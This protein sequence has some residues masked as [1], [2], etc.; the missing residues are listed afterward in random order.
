MTW[1][2]ER[3]NRDGS[4]AARTYCQTSQTSDETTTTLTLGRALDSDMVID[5]PYVAASHVRLDI[6]PDGNVSVI[7]LGTKNKI[8][9]SRKKHVDSIVITTDASQSQHA[10]FYVGQTQM[11]LTRTDWP[12]A[13]ER[14]LSRRN[15]WPYAIT[16]FIAALLYSA[17]NIWLG[18]VGEKP[19]QYLNLIAATAAGLAIWSA[20]YAIF[21]RLISGVDRMFSHLA[22]ACIGFLSGSFVL[23]ILETF[24]FATSW[25]WPI[26]ITDTVVVIAAAMTVAFHLK[27]ADPRHWRS[28]RIAIAVIACLAIIVPI[29]QLWILEGRLTRIQTHMAVK[30]PA[31]RFSA[32]ITQESLLNRTNDLKQKVD[33]DR[34]K[35]DGGDDGDD[36]GY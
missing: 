30:H 24:A 20:F 33:A 1:V 16:A 6:T 25:L 22:I 3:L 9:N 13:D 27:L 31:L 36:G 26:R 29:A 12:V 34:K 14:L 8:I 11:R 19:P 7:D 5:D 21:G 15:I 17:Y 4:V 2:L 35:N 18:D 28:T 32:P 23:N 10:I